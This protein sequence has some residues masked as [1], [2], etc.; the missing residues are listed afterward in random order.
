[1]LIYFKGLQYAR[2]ATVPF[3]Q[4]SFWTNKMYLTFYLYGWIQRIFGPGLLVSRIFAATLGVFSVIGIWIM[5]R[6]FSNNWL[7]AASVWA[8]ALNPTM[9]SIYSIGNSQ[10][11]V[12]FFL[13][14]SLV[15]SL[16]EGRKN[17]EIVLGAVLA[18]IMVLSRENM[19]FVLPLFAIYAFWQHGKKKGILA[20]VSLSTILLIG[21]LVFW[22]EI[23]YLWIRWLPF[24]LN[25]DFPFTSINTP[26]V[27]SSS[28]AS[29]IH[30]FGLAIRVFIVPIAAILITLIL[31][32]KKF[33]WKSGV[34][35][36]TAVFLVT[37]LLVL[38]ASHTWASIGNDYCVY[39]STNY[40]AFFM[41]IGLILFAVS[42]SSF[43]HKPSVIRLIAIIVTLMASGALISFSYFESIGYSLMK[44][45]VPRV[46][47]GRILPGTVELWQMLNNK[48]QISYESSRLILPTLL[49]LLI[50]IAF[51]LL[52][53][54]IYRKIQFSNNV[55]YPFFSSLAIMVVVFLISPAL[56]WPTQEAFS[57]I[58]VT[59]AFKK[60]GE[61]VAQ[62]TVPG[63]KVYIDG[64][65]TAIP[66]IY[67]EGLEYL[68]PQ[69]NVR[70]SY[71]DDPDSDALFKGWV[72]ERRNCPGLEE[73]IRF[74]YNRAGRI[75][76]LVGVYQTS[77]TY[78]GSG[79]YQLR[80]HA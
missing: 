78:R 23:L 29:R 59:S 8:M 6:R 45:T 13:V 37:V 25:L 22:P 32:V 11:V 55:S 41:P 43:S 35:F 16:G 53:W 76:Q 64:L 49:G 66:L 31:W 21:H 14:W 39:C 50:G 7:A 63:E 30:S 44:F 26:D 54:I 3:E 80:K 10:V 17:W 65:T 5:V 57:N 60:I 69:I 24:N 46:R 68:P 72:L 28:F 15:F 47:E 42:Q 79:R 18:A 77:K 36:K 71:I 67:T 51:L 1:M 34:N 20:L 52:F 27:E 70:F 48:Y 58:S 12:I 38:I 61:A 56:A 9:I 75:C 33:S 73:T 74:I 19:I 40:Y 4:Y 2:G 62:S